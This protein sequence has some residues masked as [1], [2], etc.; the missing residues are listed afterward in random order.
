MT[1]KNY[2]LLSNLGALNNLNISAYSLSSISSNPNSIIHI[3]MNK[4]I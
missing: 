1:I 3:F 4:G 2:Y